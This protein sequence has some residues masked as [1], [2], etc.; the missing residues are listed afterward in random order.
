M[1][2]HN[3]RLMSVCLG[4]LILCL[5]L[6]LPSDGSLGAGATAAKQALPASNISWGQPVN[7]S[8]T[9]GADGAN[10]PSAAMHPTNPLLALSGGNTTMAATQ[11]ERSGN[12]GNSWSNSGLFLCPNPADENQD[13][14]M[15]WLAGNVNNGHSALFSYICKT[16]RLALHISKS[17]NDGANWT[18]L[19]NSQID[20]GNCMSQTP[21]GHDREYLWTDH[22]SSSPYYGRTYLTEV[23]YSTESSS[24]S[25]WPSSGAITQPS[26]C[27]FPNFLA[28]GLRYTVNEGDNWST[29][30]STGYDAE[31]KN[32]TYYNEFPALAI[33]PNGNVV[34]VWRRGIYG[35]CINNTNGSNIMWARSANGGASFAITGTVAHIDYN[36][37]ISFGATSPGGFRWSDA[38]NI[39]ADPVDAT[40][41]AVWAQYR[42]ANQPNSAAIYLSK[43]TNN[44]DTWSTPMIPYVPASGRYQYF[45]WVQ[46]SGDHV[47]HLTFSG[48]VSNDHSVAHFYTQSTDS[49]A[50]WAAPVPLNNGEYSTLLLNPP[51]LGDYEST[52]IGGYNGTTG[53]ILTTWTSSMTGGYENRWARVGT[54]P[55]AGTPVPTPT[56][57]PGTC[58]PGPDYSFTSSTSSIVPGSTLVSGSQCD[59]CVAPITLPFPFTLY[60]SSGV[61]AGPQG[62]QSFTS[63]WVSSN[64][65]LQFETQLTNAHSLGYDCPVP[66]SNFG[67]TIFA[68]WG[69]LRTDQPQFGVFTSTSGTAPNRIFNIEW[70]ACQKDDNTGGCT[71]SANF[72]IRL[73]EGQSK[74]DLF[75]NALTINKDDPNNPNGTNGVSTNP[76]V[77]YKEEVVV[78]VQQN[79][80]HYTPFAC[81]TPG[82]PLYSGTLLTFTRQ[83]YCAPPTNTPV[84][85][86]TPT[87]TPTPT[88][89]PTAC[90]PTPTPDNGCSVQFTDVPPGSTFYPYVHCLACLNPPRPPIV[91]GYP[92]GGPGEPCTCSNWPYYRPGNDVWRGQL[93]KIV[94]LARLLS[95]NSNGQLYQDVPPGSTYYD[96]VNTLT[97]HNPQVVNG[98]DCGG[99]DEPCVPPNN[100]PYFRL[101]NPAT[102]GQTAKIVLL[103][104]DDCPQASRHF[105]DVAYGSTFYTWVERLA[106]QGAVSGYAC[107]GI[108]EPCV[109]PGNLPYY[110]PNNVTSRGQAAQIIKISVY[111]SCPYMRSLPGVPGSLPQAS[112]TAQ[113]TATVPPPTLSVTPAGTSTVVTGTGTP[114]TPTVPTGS[115]TPQETVI[116][117]SPWPT[118]PLPIPTGYIPPPVPTVP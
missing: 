53:T 108:D 11:A 81:D 38:P 63:A 1:E 114:T 55:M 62:P 29:F 116:V 37:A 113:Q 91:D 104:C 76:N 22:N 80:S 78:G 60:G 52:S 47:V 14:V 58:P 95:I 84:P 56:A 19:T 12:G 109:P 71:A 102:R 20:N 23:E 90:P 41:Y 83:P 107:G 16:P 61:P 64:G 96:Y 43:S 98:Y 54:F 18:A 2:R 68:Y 8:N 72:E 99:Q 24:F 35:T 65:N 44:G 6:L 31:A 3:W 25:P 7:T 45:P 118:V 13:G 92:C 111:P 86:N 89:T 94:V 30:L 32:Q 49:G 75:Y 26:D 9:T 50:T 67:Q 27:T 69:D 85:T 110:R 28:V 74:F 59:N 100:L 15:T 106:Q 10:E 57:T 36:Y 4:A 97:N 82:A 103:A 88:F 46:V 17:T 105:Q 66:I 21:C 33:Q 112:V 77:G 42:V 101:N 34:E 39:A 40:L 73:Y 87:R 117:P 51:M 79:T 70:R 5:A 93:S 48:S 115:P